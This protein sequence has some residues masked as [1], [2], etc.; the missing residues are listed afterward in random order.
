MYYLGSIKIVVYDK[1]MFI[2]IQSPML[3][4]AP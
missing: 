1:K 2:H 4:N 3:N